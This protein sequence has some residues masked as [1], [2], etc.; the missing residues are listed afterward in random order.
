[1]GQ[2]SFPRAPGRCQPSSWPRRHRRR[3]LR[4]NDHG[5]TAAL[6]TVMPSLPR[7]VLMRLAEQ[8]ILDSETNDDPAHEQ[9][10]S[11]E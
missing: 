3:W 8:M 6:L 5:S 7:P 11:Y 4:A 9:E 1:M 10:Q 2:V